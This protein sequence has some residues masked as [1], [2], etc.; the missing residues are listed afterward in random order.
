M[1]PETNVESHKT[2]KK[3]EYYWSITIKPNIKKKIMQGK[4]QFLLEILGVANKEIAKHW[5]NNK[6]IC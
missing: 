3:V 1:E 5:E 2:Q 6:T 4:S